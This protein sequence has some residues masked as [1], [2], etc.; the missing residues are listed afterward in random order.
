MQKIATLFIAV[1]ISAN[2]FATNFTV[3]NTNDSGEGSLRAAMTSATSGYTGSHNIFFN[4]PTSDPNY[5]AQDGTFTINL[6]SE[7]PFSIGMVSIN[8]DGTTQTSFTGDT[9]PYGPEIVINGGNRN[10]QS[11]FRTAS[12]GCKY[13]GLAIGGFTYG[14]MFFG[15]NGGTVSDCYIGIKATGNEAFDNTNTYGIG[16]SGGTYMGVNAGYAK[17]INI[18]NNVISGNATAGIVL[19]GVSNNT[20]SGNKIGTNYNAT[21]TVPNYQGIYLSAN[22][23]SN[24]IS[25]N[26]I[27]GNSLSAIALEGASN[28]TI[29]ANKIGTNYDGTLAI[30]NNQGI[31]LRSSAQNNIIGGNSENQRN[32]LSGNTNA[33]IV[34]ENSGTRNNVIKGNYIGVDASGS[35]PLSNHYGVIAMTNANSN[36]IGGTT[37]GERNIISA[38]TEIGVYIESCDS[39]VVCGNIIGLDKTGTQMFKFADGDSLIQANGTEINTTGKHNIIG[40]STPEERNIISGNRV[41]GCIYYG[42]CSN[43]NI[44]GNYIGTDINGEIA[45]PNAT[46]ICVDG[47]SHQ[48][49]MENNVLSGNRSYGLFIVTRGTDDNIFRGNFVGT[50]ASGTSALPNDVGLMLAADAKRNIIGG[51]SE[52]DRNIFSGN[53]Y[54]G[55]EITDLGTENNIIKG[56]YIGVDATGNAAL[57]NENGIIVSALVKHLTIENNIISANRR[58]SDYTPQGN[59]LQGSG[60]GIVITD[61]AESI[62]VFN[63]KIGT[64]KYT[65]IALGNSASGILI[66]GGAT[67]CLIGGPEKGNIIANNDT[68]GIVL[69]DETTLNN[70]ISQNSFYSNHYS[71]IDIQPLGT[72]DN[73]NGDLDEGCNHLMNYPEIQSVVHNETQ[74]IT[75]AS[76]ILDTQNP[77]YATIELFIA[78]AETTLGTPREGRIYL[79]SCHPNPDGWWNITIDESP[80]TTSDF[81]VATATD[82]SGNTSEFSTS[83]NTITQIEPYIATEIEV[84]PNPTNGIFEISANSEITSIYIYNMLGQC[85]RTITNPRETK[86]TI[87]ISEHSAGTYFIV[88]SSKKSMPLITKIEKQ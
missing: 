35:L 3:T 24:T 70:R 29:T 83:C 34:L 73:D 87:D 54:A 65:E 76:G 30:P 82:A 44:C 81:I 80:A 28:N 40:G 47:S 36:R 6:L 63:N 33:G 20:I 72:N 25:N 84:F 32:I 21:D 37:V 55:I 11:G 14:I 49:I 51:D 85:I 77:Q 71:G 9:N 8:V 18:T 86:L 75:W 12:G 46:G 67:N 45:M 48:N 16:L 13:K 88:I 15:S 26:V 53:L 68:A 1:I 22:S 52:S 64:G 41:Y 61:Q 38:N 58:N 50:N 66:A 19:D 74:G 5:N 62:N 23:S 42:N 57:P 17:N 2:I 7:L 69:M 59:T 39:N 4:I 10:I 27:S 31:Y 56:N 79:G 78:N 60:F 43:N